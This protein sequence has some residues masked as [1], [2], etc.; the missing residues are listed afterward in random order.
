MLKKVYLREVFVCYNY[1]HIDAQPDALAC[2]C[3]H[4]PAKIN[5]FV[6]IVF[7]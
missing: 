4:M 1:L 5:F 2:V 7:Y 3:A 6:K